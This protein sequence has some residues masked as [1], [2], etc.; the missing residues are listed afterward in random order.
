MRALNLLELAFCFQMFLQLVN[1][2]TFTTPIGTNLSLVGT[3]MFVCL[4]FSSGGGKG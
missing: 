2:D 3:L 4:L 1:R